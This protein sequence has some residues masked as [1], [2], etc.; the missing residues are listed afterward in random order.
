M[1]RWSSVCLK[2]SSAL[3][4]SL[5]KIHSAVIGLAPMP[6]SFSRKS[7]ILPATISNIY[8]LHSI[9]CRP[10]TMIVG[11]ITFN[12]LPPYKIKVIIPILQMWKLRHKFSGLTGILT[13]LVWL[14]LL[15]LTAW[16][17]IPKGFVAPRADPSPGFCSCNMFG[18]SQQELWVQRVSC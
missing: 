9:Y 16:N 15:I 13:Q 6:P 8:C 17:L 3:D 1:A 5:L 14:M 2:S 11:I 18:W 10:D 7:P 12:P 4:V